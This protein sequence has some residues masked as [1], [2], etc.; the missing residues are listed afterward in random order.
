MVIHNIGGKT[1]NQEPLQLP[2]VPDVS[3]AL[4][5][6]SLRAELQKK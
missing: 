3:V 2:D 5:A 4:D 6:L 1:L